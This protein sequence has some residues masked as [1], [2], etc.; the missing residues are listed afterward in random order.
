MKNYR[1]FFLSA[2]FIVCSGMAAQ[3]VLTLEELRDKWKH[4]NDTISLSSYDIIGDG[5]YYIEMSESL[6]SID[7][8]SLPPSKW[9]FFCEDSLGNYT[10]KEHPSSASKSILC[11][12]E[13]KEE[14]SDQEAVLRKHLKET[15]GLLTGNNQHGICQGIPARWFDGIINVMG[16]LEYRLG[17]WVSGEYSMRNYKINH[18]TM[19]VEEQD[20][21]NTDAKKTFKTVYDIGI[22]YDD[23]FKYRYDSTTHMLFQNRSYEE[24]KQFQLDLLAN[25]IALFNPNSDLPTADLYV[26]NMP[27]YVYQSHETGHL[28]MEVLGDDNYSDI[29]RQEISRLKTAFESLPPGSYNKCYYTLDGILEGEL[30]YAH[31]DYGYLWTF[32]Y[33][34]K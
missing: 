5:F 23:L 30:L 21:T 8:T 6:R 22:I 2:S 28:V 29:Q 13:P 10:C 11:W 19:I 20:D 24:G 18:G 33:N 31:Y 12:V 16:N 3:H 15:Y 1:F 9:L 27:I 4:R 34:P 32:S 7:N 26:K 25:N 14:Y 17:N